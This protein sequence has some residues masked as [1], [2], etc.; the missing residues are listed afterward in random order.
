MEDGTFQE[1]VAIRGVDAIRI[2]EKVD[3]AIAAPVLCAVGHMKTT[4][5]MELLGLNCI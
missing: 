2:P 5:I 4:F 1:Y 3:L